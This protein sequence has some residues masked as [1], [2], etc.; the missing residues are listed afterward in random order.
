MY[1][2]GVLRGQLELLGPTRTGVP[3]VR[4]REWGR[5]RRA[6]AP[7]RER[8]S[9]PSALRREARQSKRRDRGHSERVRL[10]ARLGA[11]QKRAQRGK[12][13]SASMQTA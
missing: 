6:G 9:A 4:A 10:G 3:L 13:G 12:A 2:F 1:H 7:L 11:P 8:K 5:R